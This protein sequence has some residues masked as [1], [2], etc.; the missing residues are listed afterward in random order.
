MKKPVK[1]FV[2]VMREPSAM[3]FW[4]NQNLAIE[5][6]DTLNGSLQATYATRWLKKDDQALVPGQ[7][8]I[9]IKGTGDSLENVLSAYANAA[10][11]PIPLFVLATNAASQ[12]IEIELG[13]ETTPGVSE[14]EYFQSYIPPESN[15]AHLGRNINI[16]ATV[17]LLN[18]IKNN[19]NQ[20]RL[21]RAAN[22]YHLALNTWKLGKE[23]MSLAHLW[24]ALEALTK[25]VVRNECA[26]H[27]C[28]TEA[29]LANTLGVELKKLD[30]T[31]RKNLILNGDEECY[32]K[33]KE[34]SDG[35]EHGFLGYDKI[36]DNAKDVRHQMA[37]YI[38]KTIIELAGAPKEVVEILLSAPFNEPMGHLPI[39]KYLRG[40]LLGKSENLSM[41]GNA[42]PFIKWSHTIKS[43]LPNDNGKLT[44]EITENMTPELSEGTLFRPKSLEAWKP[45]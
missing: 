21:I 34:A 5:L 39:A 35:L 27:G 23:S 30:A 36:R 33:A 44:Y 37:Q 17:E 28:K 1:T 19:T 7:L 26:K 16:A 38:R 12:D 8:W 29:D 14:R 42:Y 45:D 41:E 22:Q 15:V 32:K 3:V 6:T 2:V 18:A 31:I 40:H 11:V 4:Q 9:E 43:C 13:Y 25:V 20:E 10:L 24:M